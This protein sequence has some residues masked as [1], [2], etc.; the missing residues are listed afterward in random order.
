VIR[1]VRDGIVVFESESLYEIADWL[2][3]EEKEVKELVVTPNEEA[4]DKT[5]ATK[6]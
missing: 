1:I 3:Y 6:R 2:Y 5:K 4:H